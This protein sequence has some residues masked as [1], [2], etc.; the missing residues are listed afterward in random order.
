MESHTIKLPEKSS[1]LSALFDDSIAL[2]KASSAATGKVQ[3]FK[4]R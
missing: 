2:D 3:R 4:L 1:H